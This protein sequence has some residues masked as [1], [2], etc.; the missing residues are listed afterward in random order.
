MN[1]KRFR[2][3]LH[4]RLRQRSPQRKAPG[5]PRPASPPQQKAQRQH[6]LPPLPRRKTARAPRRRLSRRQ[7]ALRPQRKA[8]NRLRK[9]PLEQ[10]A[11]MQ[12]R[13]LSKQRI[14]PVKTAGGLLWA[15]LTPYGPGTA[16]QRPGRTAG[17]R[18]TYPNTPPGPTLPG[19]S[20]CP[21]TASTRTA[22]MPSPSRAP[23]R[24][25]GRST[26]SSWSPPM[27]TPLGTQ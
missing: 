3:S 9:W 18:Q 24:T 1:I 27:T 20:W 4:R 2:S 14:P 7:P 11:G 16:I 5:R 23:N 26:P 10:R 19:S 25:P 12:T 8:Q 13:N 22:P 21:A 6:P 15:P 17:T